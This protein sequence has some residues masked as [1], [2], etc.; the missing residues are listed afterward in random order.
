M[1]TT[2]EEWSKNNTIGLV[3]EEPTNIKFA[4]EPWEGQ[5]GLN[6]VG[7]YVQ[8]K[9]GTWVPARQAGC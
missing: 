5:F 1:N 7:E 2:H 4:T 9:N 8:Y 6:N 3:P